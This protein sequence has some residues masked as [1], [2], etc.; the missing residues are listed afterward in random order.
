MVTKALQQV[1][2]EKYELVTV[3]RGRQADDLEAT[4]LTETIRQS[5]PQLEV[6]V[7]PGGQDLYPFILSVE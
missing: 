2:A 6:E 4:G 5:F 3:Y 7:Q 1:G